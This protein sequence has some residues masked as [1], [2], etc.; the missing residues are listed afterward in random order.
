MTHLKD[1]SHEVNEDLNGD[2]FKPH[3]CED[4]DLDSSLLA[5]IIENLRL[6]PPRR[7]S[8]FDRLSAKILSGTSARGADPPPFPLL[9]NLS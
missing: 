2:I 7:V 3:G 5:E 8:M 1:L 9:E 6:L 4:V